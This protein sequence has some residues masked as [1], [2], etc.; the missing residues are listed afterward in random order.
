MGTLGGIYRPC[1]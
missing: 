1:T